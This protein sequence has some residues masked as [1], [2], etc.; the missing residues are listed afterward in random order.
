MTSQAQAI[1]PL[2]GVKGLALLGFPLHPAGKPSA[3][4]A[5]HLRDVKI[6]MLFLQGT[7]DE[8]AELELLQPLIDRLGARATLKLLPDAD[9]SFHVPARTGRKD[10]EVR[11]E[12]LDAF[13][14]WIEQAVPN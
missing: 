3:E 12:M 8:L 1:A 2:P 13:A 14:A 5:E 10:A 9:H 11:A 4:R 6:P 7:R